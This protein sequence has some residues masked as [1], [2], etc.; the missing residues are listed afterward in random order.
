MT[1]V[2]FLYQNA[3]VII[4]CILL[5]LTTYSC[6]YLYRLSYKSQFS[7]P[8]IES[9]Q[10]KWFHRYKLKSKEI[11]VYLLIKNRINR[12]QKYR[13]TNKNNSIGHD[14]HNQ[15]NQNKT[16]SFSDKYRDLP[17]VS[18]VVP[19]RNEKK[20][21]ERC[22]MSLLGQTYPEFEIIVIDDNST[23]ATSKILKNILDSTKNKIVSSQDVTP[24]S[25]SNTN[26]LKI[27]HNFKG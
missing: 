24:N 14:D 12:L 9:E 13:I 3:E 25:M 5:S 23:D 10:I 11:P 2:T 18:I 4:L 21:I 17:F 16:N 1:T 6:A 7:I 20:Y 27:D 8:I 15:I 26:R 19:A 22:I